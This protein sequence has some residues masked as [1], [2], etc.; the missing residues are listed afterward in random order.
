MMETMMTGRWIALVLGIVGLFVAMDRARGAA[1]DAPAMPAAPPT[2]VVRALKLMPSSLTLQNGRDE[3]RF[4]VLGETES[5]KTVDLTAS[6]VVKTDSKMIEVG[7]DGYIRGK[8]KGAAEVTVFAGNLQAKVLVTVAGVDVPTMGFVRDIAP[9][10]AKVGC[11]AGTCHGAAK[12]KEG[13]KLS[14]RGYDTEFDYQALINDLGGRRFNRVMPEE[15]LMM[16]KPAGMVP[17][18]GGKVLTPG[19]RHYE[20][21]RKWIAEGTKRE[22]HAARANSIEVIPDNVY[23]DLPGMSQQMLVIAH[24][25]DGSTRDVTREAIFS[26][27]NIEVLAIK[28]NSAVSLR[29]GEGAVLVRYEGN[30]ATAPMICMGDRSGYAWTEQPQFNYIDRH[31][32]AKLQAMKI[33][34]SGLCTDAEFAR[35]VYLDLTGQPTTP[36]RVKAFLADPS[37][38]LVKRAKLVDELLASDDYVQFWSNKWADLLQ[39]NSTSLGQKGLWTFRGWLRSAIARNEPYDQLVRE[40]LLARGSSYTNPEVSYYR[41]LKDTGKITEDVS[42]TFLGVRFNCNKC[43]DHPF[44]K[45]TQNQYYEF[46]AYFSRI[47]FKN[48]QMPGEQI[49]YDN[50]DGGETHHPKTDMVVPPKVPYGHVSE[51]LEKT[52]RRRAFVDWLTSAENPY[53]AKSMS[54]RVWS[55]FFG[56]GIIDPVDDIR[57]SNPPSNSALLDALTDDFVSSKFNVR[58]LMRTICLSR[59]YQQSIATNKWNADDKINY[60]HALPRRMTAEQLVDAVALATGYRAPY[61]GM[62]TGTRAVMLPDGTGEALDVLGLFGKPKRQS[63][64]E[65]ERTSNFALAHAIN[66]VNGSTIGDA[67]VAPNGRIA[68]IVATQ[69]DDRKVVEELYFAIMNR[70]PA[71]KE[72]EGINLGQ[73]PKRL[74]MAQ[75]IAWALLNSPAFLYNR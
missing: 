17:H 13:F 39:A 8:E 16:L 66:L 74:E 58:H 19:S 29:R 68:R 42:Q 21:M 36:E 63:A 5:G 51:S 38:S 49:I 55:Y 22:S 40:L 60:S 26:S 11:N 48:G 10:I 33:L 54:N 7:A 69:S 25:R 64:C 44:E 15:S 72:L 3:R 35:R 71:D 59:T 34:P 31:V 41:A 23:L 50:F 1:G 12:G 27:S 67:V 56:R 73:G 24:Y 52:D 45:W 32:D 4:L 20:M 37:E 53:F 65:C 28:D 6:A 46:G 62:P 2:P 47:A 57:G 75:D 14:L 70:P 18:E 9:I 30:Y 43:H 61:S